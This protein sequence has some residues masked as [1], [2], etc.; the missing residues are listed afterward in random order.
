MAE[1]AYCAYCHEYGYPP[2]Q[3]QHLV[4]FAKKIGQKATWS[5]CKNMIKTAP[6]P[7]S[8][9]PPKKTETKKINNNETQQ[10]EPE[11][12]EKRS[13]LNIRAKGINKRSS[14]YRFQHLVVQL[15]AMGWEYSI[16]LAA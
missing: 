5:E 3:P 15:T 1:Q 2:K 12:K 9:V 16:A 13:S 10:S 7:S 14:F 8:Y 4:A 11:N 6:D